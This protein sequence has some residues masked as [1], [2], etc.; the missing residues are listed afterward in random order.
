VTI[1]GNWTGWIGE[2]S[3]TRKVIAIEMQGHGRTADI[4]RSNLYDQVI[5]NGPIDRALE[6]ADECRAGD[7]TY[8]FAAVADVARAAQAGLPRLSSALLEMDFFGARPSDGVLPENRVFNQP[9]LRLGYFQLEHK[10]VKFVFGQDKMIF[11]PLDPVSLS[12]VGVPLGATA[13]DLW[14]WFPQARMDWTHNIGSTGLLVQVG[15]LRAISEMLPAKAPCPFSIICG[16]SAG[17]I[18]ATVLA[19][20]AGNF[21][22]GVRQLMTVWKNFHAYHVYRTDLLGVI[23]NSGKWLWAGIF[24]GV[25]G[26]V[27]RCPARNSGCKSRM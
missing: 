12:H 4:D 17:A 10:S 13:G 3:K 19:A 7:G 15:V 27:T 2:L 6:L 5:R 11:A 23:N 14:G 9:R 26:K 22:R 24:G 21:R 1:P 25:G 18:N 8:P 16:T 20:N